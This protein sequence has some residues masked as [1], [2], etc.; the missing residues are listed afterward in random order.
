MTAEEFMAHRNDPMNVKWF[1][2][3]VWIIVDETIADWLGYIPTFI[4]EDSDKTLK[5]QID[6][7]YPPGWNVWKGRHEINIDED[8]LISIK[9]LDYPEDP[10][11]MEKARYVHGDQMLVVCDYAVSAIIN[12]KTGEFEVSRLD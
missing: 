12:L 1:Y 6:S 11:Y 5:E 2:P 9:S 8:S 3:N 10:E 4:D 7:A